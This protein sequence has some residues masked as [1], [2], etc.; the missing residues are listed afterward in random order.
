MERVIRGP[1]VDFLEST[2][3]LDQSQHGA[4]S[5]RSTLTQLLVH[6]DAVLKMI[7]TGNN[8]ELVYLDFAKAF[9]K[10]DHGILLT[11]LAGMGIRGSLG[12]WIGKFLHLRSQSVRVGSSIS[13]WLHVVSGVP[14]GTVLGPLLFLC[15]IADLGADL[16]PGSSLLLKYVDDT[17]AVKEISSLDDV[18][19]M[20]EDLEALYQWQIT[21]NMEWN[22]SKFQSLRM[23]TNHCLR[24]ESLLF[25]PNFTDPIPEKD[26]VKDLGVLMDRGGTFGPQRA[27]ANA[28]AHQKAGWCLRTFRSRDLGTLKT[29]WSSLIRPHQDYCSQ[30]WSPVGLA[31]ELLK[32]ES[33]LR[34]FTKRIRGFSA[35][36]YWERLAAASMYST[37]RRQERYKIIY[38]WK[39]LRGLVPFCG[40]SEDSPASSRRGRTITVPSL[41]GS[42]RYKAIRTLRDTSFQSEGPKL[43]NSL[44]HDLRN[45]DSSAEVFKSHL[46]KYLQ[47]IPDH[48]AVPGYVPAA[49]RANG[50]PSNSVRDWPRR[51][52]AVSWMSSSA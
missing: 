36:S 40:L 2:S 38:S 32:Q 19:D 3:Q 1:I 15:F 27:S 49:Q 46:D 20:Q 34:A 47:T 5:G 31:G 42:D 43:F 21:N 16:G 13:S 4:R 52:Q 51:I 35:L 24:N 11:K 22:S 12:R 44:P 17:K 18:E 14:Q 26:V 41:N 23:G 28:K 48:P 7:E 25:T 33:P 8:C 30:L 39:A 10:V 50:S 29:L 45:L 37:E 9:N 6:Y